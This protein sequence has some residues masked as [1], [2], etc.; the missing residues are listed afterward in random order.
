MKKFFAF[1]VILFL[2]Q[3]FCQAQQTEGFIRKAGHLP[4]NPALKPFYHGVASGDPLADRVIIWTR[5]TPDT[6]TQTTFTVNWVMATDTS[7]KNIVKKGTVTTDSTKDFTVKVDVTG[8]SPA[9]TYYYGFSWN[10]IYS[11]IGRARTAP[12]GNTDH[13][14]FAVVSCNN[15]EAGFF[16]A[17]ARIAERNDLDAVIHLGDYIYEYQT[18]QAGDSTTGRFVEP[19]NEAVTEGDYRTRYSVYKLDPELQRAHQQQTFIT[20]WDDH[21]SSNDSY[22]DGAQNHQP[23]TE[24]DWETRKAISKKVY[25]EWLPIRDYPDNTVYR[26]VSYGAMADIFLLDTRLEGRDKPPVNFDDPDTPTRTILGS[27]QYQWFTNG[28]KNSTAK[29]K[30]VGNQVIFSN[31]NVGFASRNGQGL[32]DPSNINSIRTAERPFNNFWKS[33]PTERSAIIDSIEQNNINNVVFITGDSHASWAF[34]VT[35]QPVIYPDA[36]NSNYA[37]PSPTYNPSTGQGSVAVE[38]CTPSI[39]SANFD[40]RFG[41][42][43]ANQFEAWVNT[44]VSF[45]KNSNY[46]PHLKFTNVSQH[47]YLVLDLKEDSAQASYYFCDKINTPSKVENF[48]KTALTL[49]NSN[50]IL[51]SN[52]PSP[53]KT[54]QEIP[55]P[56]QKPNPLAIQPTQKVVVFH[57]YPNPAH[58][59]FTLQYGVA[60]NSNVTIEVYTIDGKKVENWQQVQGAGYYNYTINIADWKRGIYLYRISAGTAISSGKFLVE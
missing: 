5:I 38:F 3:G 56:T 14:R 26:K 50:R 49:N 2:A 44:P 36:Q 1:C 43:L 11:T 52:L 4:F 24:G 57:A 54:Q 6:T 40:E 25:F 17:F 18:K 42:P 10:T 29:W 15:Y 7:L 32:P 53:N 47:G 51:L 46:N 19:E 30:V 22:K 55:A 23:A 13:L 20:V 39:T 41:A 27:T 21:E 28:L 9:T 48:A 37:S 35:P 8:L 45:L 16:N 12:T 34:D 31:L 59:I 33:Y 58:S 60:Q